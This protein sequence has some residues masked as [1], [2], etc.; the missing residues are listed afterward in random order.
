[1]K[2]NGRE[3]PLHAG[4]IYGHGADTSFTIESSD[5]QP[6]VRYFVNFLGPR[7]QKLFEKGPLGEFQPFEMAGVRWIEEVFRQLL[8]FGVKRD[9]NSKRA[10]ALLVELLLLEIQTSLTEISDSESNAIQTFRS[11]RKYLE[12][13]FIELNSAAELAA[14][15]ELD[16]TYLTR[17]FQRYD[18]E[19]PYKKL[20]RLKMNQAARLLANNHNSVKDVAVQVGFKDPAH[21]SRVFKNAFGVSPRQVRK[22]TPPTSLQK[23]G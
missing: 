6:L 17:I 22:S 16:Q 1:M 20:V 2:L 19:S 11:C 14:A 15:M 3:Y 23:R 8:K 10:C 18:D 13:N 12:K 21:F 4:K 9:A 5:T 7:A